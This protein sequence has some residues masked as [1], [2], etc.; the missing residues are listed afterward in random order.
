MSGAVRVGQGLGQ[1]LGDAM[2]KRAA[3]RRSRPHQ[4]EGVTKML[5]WAAPSAPRVLSRAHD[6]TKPARLC[7]SILL[8][9]QRGL[10]HQCPR[11]GPSNQIRA[12]HPSPILEPHQWLPV[13][14]QSVW[15]ECSHPKVEDV[16]LLSCRLDDAANRLA[17]FC[18]R[19]MQNGGS[20]FLGRQHRL[21]FLWLG[22][23]QC[24]NQWRRRRHLFLGSG[25]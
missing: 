22:P 7:H 23:F 11:L 19:G 8:I 25:G 21:R 12:L 18:S 5:I 3:E 10:S 15:L 4:V 17:D 2:R 9:T 20:S 24:A 13:L 16:A 14:Q 6:E 1:G